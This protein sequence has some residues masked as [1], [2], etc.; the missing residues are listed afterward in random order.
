MSRRWTYLAL[1]IGTPL[2]LLAALWAWTSTAE[3][4]YFPPLGDVLTA[5]RVNWL[6]ERFGQDVVPS[7]GRA[8]AGYAIAVVLG[9]G[10]G[11]LLGQ[12]RLL[13]RGLE[14]VV[15]FL[16]AV[17][18]PALLPFALL[19]FGL[20]AGMKIFIIAL[21]CLWPVLLSTVEGV[22]S[23]DPV[24]RE[25]ARVYRITPVRLLTR[26]VLPSASPKILAGM[27]TSLALSVVMMVVSELV[28]STDGIGYFVVQS[29]RSYAIADMWSGIVLLGLVGYLLNS[30]FLLVERRVLRWHLAM[31]SRG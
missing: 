20:G 5:F 17:P 31:R 27:R 28:A 19:V 4:L 11:L 10:L 15:E 1:E 24:L 29:Q 16:R 18:P 13:R 30:A 26:V 23:V 12:V 9:V 3:S 22:R 2:V 7:L 8:A 21:V 14:P 25:T 6:F